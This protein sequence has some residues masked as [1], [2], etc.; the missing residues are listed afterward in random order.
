MI[1]TIALK[2]VKKQCINN[3]VQKYREGSVTMYSDLAHSGSIAARSL[4][5][6]PPSTNPATQ[7]MPSDVSMYPFPAEDPRRHAM[8]KPTN[9]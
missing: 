5:D 6:S 8:L 4:E 3:S 9:P 2:A 1:D 7:T